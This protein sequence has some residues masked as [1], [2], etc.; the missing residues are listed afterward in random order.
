MTPREIQ[1]AT[2]RQSSTVCWQATLCPHL[3]CYVPMPQEA[4]G[5]L[6]RLSSGCIQELCSLCVHMVQAEAVQHIPGAQLCLVW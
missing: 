4:E 3:H 2:K 5:E 6:Q 1:M